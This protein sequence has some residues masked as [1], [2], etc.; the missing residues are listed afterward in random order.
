LSVDDWKIIYI[1]HPEKDIFE[2]YNI[3]KDPKENNNLIDKEK[4][5]AEE[6]KK[7]I[8]DFLKTQSNEGEPKAENLTEKSRKL[9]IQAGY[10]E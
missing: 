5:K 2:L 1:P 10:L 4:E 8:L 6:M 9:L 7:R 3:K